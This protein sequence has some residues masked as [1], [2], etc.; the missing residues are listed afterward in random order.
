MCANSNARFWIHVF[1]ESMDLNQS[2]HVFLMGLEKL[3]RI[4]QSQY[5]DSYV[6]TRLVGA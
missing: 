6:S 4:S 2:I 3:R 5:H 1:C